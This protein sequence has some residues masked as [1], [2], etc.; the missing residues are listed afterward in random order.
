MAEARE[1]VMHQA[2]DIAV[3]GIAVG[4][5]VIAA[6]IAIA[7]AVPWL[8]I[9]AVKAPASAPGDAVRPRIERGPVQETAPMEDIAAFRRGKMERLE[10]DGV[11]AATGRAHISIE[12]AMEILVSRAAAGPKPGAPR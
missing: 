6:G 5:G 10:T 4:A 9:G 1:A 12:H 8:V 11:D 3:R 2:G 7:I